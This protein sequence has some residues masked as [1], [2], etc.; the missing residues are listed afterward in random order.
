MQQ[1]GLE[2]YMGSVCKRIGD[3]CYN[4]VCVN[5]HFTNGCRFAIMEISSLH[6]D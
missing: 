5:E 4:P 3:L 1:V 6:S 2:R